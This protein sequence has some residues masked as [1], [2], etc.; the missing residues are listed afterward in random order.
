MKR[1][2]RPH[3]GQYELGENEKFYGDMEARGWRLKKRGAY[4]SRFEPA[5]PSGARYRIEVFHPG[6]WSADT[7]PEEQLAVFADCGWEHVCTSL[8]LY[9]FRAPAGSDAPEFYADPAQ[10]AETLRRMKRDAVW[11]WVPTAAVWGLWLLIYLTLNG[12]GKFAASFQRHLVEL[13]ALFLLAGALLL[14]ACYSRVRSAFLIT[15]TYRRMKKGVPLDHSP[16]KRR[17]VHQAVNGTLWALAL[18]SGALLALQLLTTRSADLPE[19]TADPYL[20]LSDLGYEGERTEQFGRDSG[21]T[22]SPGLLADYWDMREYL[23]DPGGLGPTL[24]QDVYRLRFPS[25]A[26]WVAEALMG[27]ATLSG[28]EDFRP[29]EVPGLDRAWAGRQEVLAV[30]GDM[31][32]YATFLPYDDFDPQAL[33]QALAEKWA[34][35]VR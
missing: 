31:A 25:M 30:K 32:A 18:L 6:A 23:A 20:L 15:R 8:P 9:I 19:E 35:S 10:Q 17:W 33:C 3:P 7:M 14:Q 16:R 28:R 34:G 26:D 5:E 27:T 29:L 24:Y 1:R 11:G 22:H 2:Y 13:P 21:V 12:A 4:F